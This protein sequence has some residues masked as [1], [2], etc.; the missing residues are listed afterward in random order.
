MQRLSLRF[1][2]FS[3]RCVLLRRIRM[4]C[5]L[6]QVFIKEYEWKLRKFK[7]FEKQNPYTNLHTN[8]IYIPS[9]RVF[10]NASSVL[11]E[12]LR[13]SFEL[14]EKKRKTNNIKKNHRIIRRAREPRRECKRMLYFQCW[15]RNG[16]EKVRFER[17][18][19]GCFKRNHYCLFI[20]EDR[21][22]WWRKCVRQR[23]SAMIFNFSKH[24]LLGMIFIQ[25]L[26]RS[27]NQTAR[28]VQYA[29][30]E[31]TNHLT[32]MIAFRRWLFYEQIF[33]STFRPP[34]KKTQ[35]SRRKSHSS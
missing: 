17:K 11:A 30:N 21:N 35:S 20:A 19:S 10:V 16:N 34:K 6:L 27:H 1:K 12:T 2:S 33:G 5:M 15:S 29:T 8:P 22:D 3:W 24:F 28:S 23:E 31:R 7:W 14:D 4:Q 18:A 32:E 26:T 13:A 25:S 9:C